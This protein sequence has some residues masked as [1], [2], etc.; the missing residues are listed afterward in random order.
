MASPKPPPVA[1]SV[2]PRFHPAQRAISPVISSA[3]FLENFILFSVGFTASHDCSFFGFGFD[4][5]SFFPPA[6]PLHEQNKSA[7]TKSVVLRV[8]IFKSGDFFAIFLSI[9]NPPS[10]I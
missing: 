4:F 5:E 3:V 1:S 7:A 8:L 2:F 6:H 9:E 10:M